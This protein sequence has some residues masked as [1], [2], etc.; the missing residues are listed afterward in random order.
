MVKLDPSL[1]SIADLPVGWRA[2]RTRQSGDWTRVELNPPGWPFKDPR[3]AEAF[4]STEVLARRVEIVKVIHDGEN[5]WHLLPPE[6]YISED[7]ALETLETIYHLDSSIAALGDLPLGWQAKRRTLSDPW[8][9]GAR[10]PDSDYDRPGFRV[11]A[12]ESSAS[13]STDVPASLNSGLKVSDNEDD[14]WPYAVPRDAQVSTKADVLEGRSPV[15]FIAHRQDGTWLAVGYDV[16]T[17]GFKLTTMENILA[18]DSSLYD[19]VRCLTPGCTAMRRSDG[20]SWHIEEPKEAK[21]KE[22][23][24]AVPSAIDDETRFRNRVVWASAITAGLVGFVIYYI[25]FVQQHAAAFFTNWTGLAALLG[26]SAVAARSGYVDAGAKSN[27][28]GI[29]Y[30]LAW[31]VGTWLALSIGLS[32]LGY[33]PHLAL[34]SVWSLNGVWLAYFLAAPLRRAQQ[35][36]N[37]RA[38]QALA[39]G[40]AAFLVILLLLDIFAANMRS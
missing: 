4:T 23:R 22:R 1:K 29:K 39:V 40:A 8:V 19:I 36:G 28:R 38:V 6:G 10:T 34:T 13:H 24:H 25:A 2:Y 37:T 21:P 27:W 3:D 30:G 18:S 35:A 12:T 32:I 14:D 5:E 7:L 26:I 16:R 17:E 15:Q 11:P 31:G 33:L 20:E 9:R